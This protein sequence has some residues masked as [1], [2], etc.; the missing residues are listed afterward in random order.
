[1]LSYYGLVKVH[2]IEAYAC[3]VPSGLC[4]DRR[5]EDTHFVGLETGAIT[6]LLTMSLRVCSIC[7]QYLSRYLPLG[8]LD[9][10]NRGVGP[11][12]VDPR[13]VVYCVSKESG[14][15]HFKVTDV[16]DHCSGGEGNSLSG[17]FTLRVGFGL[18]VGDRKFAG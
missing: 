13:H 2:R 7:F 5:E 11:E 9:R 8:V 16:L 17:T 12:D 14:K 1:M 4:M 15:A 6:P 10:G 3:R 18:V